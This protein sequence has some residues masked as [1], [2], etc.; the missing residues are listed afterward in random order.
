MSEQFCMENKIPLTLV[1]WTPWRKPKPCPVFLKLKIR[2]VN[3]DDPIE[4]FKR[5]WGF[6]TSA[7]INNRKV[8]TL[9]GGI[10]QSS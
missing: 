2:H 9:L 10:F 6:I 4:E 3:I 8:Q 7:V 5:N 1:K